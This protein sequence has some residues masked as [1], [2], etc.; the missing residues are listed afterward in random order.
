M[1]LD[2]A[3]ALQ[4]LHFISIAIMSRSIFL[5]LIISMPGRVRQ[6]LDLSQL[7]HRRVTLAHSRAAG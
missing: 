5:D 7:T 4:I 1:A 3:A 6:N 2:S